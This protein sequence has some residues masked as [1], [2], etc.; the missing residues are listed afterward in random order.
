MHPKSTKK[1]SFKATKIAK[2]FTSENLTG[3]SGLTVINDYANHLGLFERLDKQFFTVVLNA[4]KILN[5]QIFSAIIYANLC[6][7]YRLSKISTFM[8]DSLVSKLLRLKGGFEDS[9]LK[10]RLV[11]LGERGSH[12]LLETGLNFSRRCV[13]RCGL[14]RITIDC[15]STEETVFGHQQGAEKGYNPKNKGK[16]CYHPL[17]CFC[18]EMKIIVNTWFRPG[19]TYTAN[20]I[21]EFMKQTLAA[22]PKKVKQVFF[23]ADSGFFNGDLF[24]LL[25]EEGHEYLVKAKLTAKIKAELQAQKWKVINTHMAVCEF[26]YMAYGW[27]KSRNMYGVRIVKQYVERMWMGTI[28]QVPEYEYFCYCSN[29]KGLKAEKIHTLYGG[30]AECENWIENTKNQLCAGKTI[31]DDFNVNDM[32]WQLSVI[33]YNLSAIMRYESDFHVWRQ[34]H[35]TF[36]E[37]FICVPGKVISKARQTTVKMSRHYIYAKQWIRLVD[38]IPIAA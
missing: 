11:Q 21:V 19:N 22:L 7:I 5:V 6:G 10:A 12:E 36:R 35:K 37:W 24:D 26:E 4:T 23:R 38:K 9:N 18:S 34:E 16:R 30:R 27:S 1:I 25:E 17:I 20:G 2:D 31:T 29:L 33:A 13:E 32:L 8:K 14:S 3:Y 28:E 15:D